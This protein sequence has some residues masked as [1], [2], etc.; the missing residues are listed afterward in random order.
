MGKNYP[1]KNRKCEKAADFKRWET[2]LSE[3]KIREIQNR[4]KKSW[5][6]FKKD[7]KERRE[8][9][10]KTNKFGSGNK[11]FIMRAVEFWGFWEFEVEW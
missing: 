3:E 4:K 10:A 5:C 8:I 2:Q 6:G 1:N 7:F 9:Q 11:V